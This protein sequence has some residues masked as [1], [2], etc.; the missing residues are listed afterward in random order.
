MVVIGVFAY[1][2]FLKETPIDESTF[3]DAGM[4]SIAQ[5]F[6]TNGNG[7][8]SVSEASA[9]TEIDVSQAKDVTGLDVFP[10]LEKITGSGDTLSTVDLTGTSVKTVNLDGCTSLATVNVTDCSSLESLACGNSAEVV[11]LDTTGLHEQWLATDFAYTEKEGA[12]GTASGVEYDSTYDGS[13]LT[14][15]AK[16]TISGDKKTADGDA[17][18]ITYGD[19]GLPTNVGGAAITYED[20]HVSEAAGNTFV[21][22]SDGK[23]TSIT[24]SSSGAESATFEHDGQGHV[25]SVTW[26]TDHSAV[27]YEYDSQGN[28]TKATRVANTDSNETTKESWEFTYSGTQLTHA[29]RTTNNASESYTYDFTYDQS[30]K[31]SGGTMTYTKSGESSTTT[32]TLSNV[33]FDEHGNMT[34]LQVSIKHASG[35]TTTTTCTEHYKRCFTAAEDGQA[36]SLIYA[37]DP[38]LI[39][40]PLGTGPVY[41]GD[42]AWAYEAEEG[43]YFGPYVFSTASANCEV[44]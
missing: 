34:S 28:L 40:H 43:A 41:T 21:Y 17:V 35:E 5:S 15:V 2:T 4:Q 23:L 18:Q 39:S 19:D 6:D 31:I 1:N 26:P 3:P 13:L 10:N 37:Y 33:T 7:K 36:T 25:T 20:G 30:G 42:Q 24:K 27:R 12:N 9:A 44:F 32:A 11:G 22:G 38:M 16:Y 29:V 14:S 8:L